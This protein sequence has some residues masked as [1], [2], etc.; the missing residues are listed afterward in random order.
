MEKVKKKSNFK[1]FLIF[2]IVIGLIL[3]AMFA[4]YKIRYPLKYGDIIAKYSNEYKLDKTLVASLINEESSFD[5]NAVSHMNAMGLMQISPTTAKFIAEKLDDKDFV[6]ENLFDPDTNIKYGCYYLSYLKDKF[7]DRVVYLSAYNAGE[8]TVSLW[9]SSSKNSDDG[10][11]LKKIPYNITHNYTTRII[12]G[13]K[14][15]KGRL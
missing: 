14:H 15:Y 10:V 13:M 8:T 7:K 5:K 4:F 12:N 11:T 1:Y 6:V 3:L 9:L 2:F